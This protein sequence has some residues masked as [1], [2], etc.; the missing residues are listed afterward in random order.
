MCHKCR[1]HFN[2]SKGILSKGNSIA[3]ILYHVD[4]MRAPWLDKREVREI[5][6]TYPR[7]YTSNVAW[8]P[9]SSSHFL[10]AYHLSYIFFYF[11]HSH[12]EKPRHI[13]SRSENKSLTINV[14]NT[15]G[16]LLINNALYLHN[17][18][19]FI[20]FRTDGW[21]AISPFHFFSNTWFQFCN[22]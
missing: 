14:E 15:H 19:H 16:R 20:Q 13:L 22:E 17:V 7:V 1:L 6:S 10:V 9:H 2:I 12:K 18:Y 8:Q 4:I 5:V 11:T 21:R 3:T